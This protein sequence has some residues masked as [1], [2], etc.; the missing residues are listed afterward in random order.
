M[1]GLVEVPGQGIIDPFYASCSSSMDYHS[2]PSIELSTK[3][4]NSTTLQRRR[5]KLAFGVFGPG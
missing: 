1:I 5:L 4:Q 3:E 2:E